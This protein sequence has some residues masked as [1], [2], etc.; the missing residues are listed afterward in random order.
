MIPS[1]FPALQTSVARF[2]E[3]LFEF[4]HVTAEWLF[5]WD[6]RLETWVPRV[7]KLREW[8]ESFEKW[9]RHLEEEMAAVGIVVGDAVGRVC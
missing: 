2:R 7:K 5:V 3:R 9:W 1:C 4:L 6:S 8:F